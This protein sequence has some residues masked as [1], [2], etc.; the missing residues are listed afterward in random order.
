MTDVDPSA[1]LGFAPLFRDR[2]D[3][4][5][6]LAAELARYRGQNLVVLA[7]PR[8]GIPVGAVVATAL[9]ADLDVIVARKLGAPMQP[10]LAIGAVTAEG[11]RYLN[12]A[13]VRELGIPDAYLAAIT[14]RESREARRREEVFRGALRPSPVEG[15]TAIVVDDGLATGA[16]MRAALR[17]VRARR[18]TRLIMAVPV[19]P[20]ATCRDLSREADEIVCLFQPDPF[21]AVGLHYEH[22]GQASDAEIQQILRDARRSREGNGGAT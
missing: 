1:N 15:R 9:D 12:E 18:P 16:T 14:Q 19:G 2:Q 11:Q 20:P 13:I 6:Q 17:S 3:A 4:G 10:E 5:E 7:I 21:W 22:F 8:G